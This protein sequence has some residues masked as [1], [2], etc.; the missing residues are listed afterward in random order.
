[1]KILEKTPRKNP[2]NVSPEMSLRGVPR[3]QSLS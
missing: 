1:M 2:K 3:F